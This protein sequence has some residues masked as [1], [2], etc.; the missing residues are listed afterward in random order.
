M[1]GR[2]RAAIPSLDTVVLRGS[3]PLVHRAVL[4]E[5]GVRT[6]CVDHF[7]DQ[8]RGNRRP[9]PQGWVCRSVVWGLWEVQAAPQHFSGFVRKLFPWSEA[10]HL[11]SGS[12]AVLH[13]G[14]GGTPRATHE[15]LVKLLRWV[16]RK[17]CTGDLHLAGLVDVPALLKGAGH[18]AFGGSVL[19]AA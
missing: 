2:A 15:R 10:P 12:L 7:D 5:E 13:A 6:I 8:T 1:L 18:G 17:R 9:A 16:D 14:S 4:V 11:V 3:T 19:K